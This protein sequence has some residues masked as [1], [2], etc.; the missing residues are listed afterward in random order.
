MIREIG[1]SLTERSASQGSASHGLQR[2]GC[3]P[4]LECDHRQP[5]KHAECSALRCSGHP[6]E[7]FAF[8]GSQPQ[9]WGCQEGWVGALRRAAGGD[10]AAGLKDIAGLSMA[11]GY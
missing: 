2:N 7:Y 11:R 10:I 4:E 6:C 9:A 3:R 5:G 8:P 1:L